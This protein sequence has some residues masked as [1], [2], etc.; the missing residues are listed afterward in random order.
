MIIFLFVVLTPYFSKQ[1]LFSFAF[2]YI[3]FYELKRCFFLPS[4]VTHVFN[5]STW[6]I[7]AGGFPW[8]QGQPDLQSRFHDSQG[9]LYK[10]TLSPK[11][12]G[13]KENF[14]LC[15]C[16]F[17]CRGVCVC[18]GGDVWAWCP[19]G[20]EEGVRSVITTVAHG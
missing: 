10:E 12:R 2:I 6:A 17:V 4:M 13:K 5:P 3:Y 19:Q 20:P 11:N 1:L 14:T 15:I 18:G 9:L 7:E 16:L 8:V